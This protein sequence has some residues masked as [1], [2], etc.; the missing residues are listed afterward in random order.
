ME[1]EEY[2]TDQEKEFMEIKETALAN[3]HLYL[4]LGSLGKQLADTLGIE[5]RREKNLD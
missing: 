3:R 2:Y 4:A 1:K 5:V